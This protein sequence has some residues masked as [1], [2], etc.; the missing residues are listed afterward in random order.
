MKN[1]YFKKWISLLVVAGMLATIGTGLIYVYRQLTLEK[2]ILE[3][4]DK[5]DTDDIL[6]MLQRDWYW[7]IAGADYSPQLLPKYRAMFK[8]RTPNHDLNKIGQLKIKVIRKDG[9]L[10]G[11]IAYHMKTSTNGF[12]LF[13]DINPSYRG[14]GYAEKLIQYALDDF[15]RL[16]AIY[17]RIF[18]RTT[19]IH[20]QNLYKRM[21]FQETSR[22]DG[23]MWFQKFI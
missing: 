6:D 22:D 9:N 10:V 13:L 2:E 19:N 15:K 17:V 16:G 12:L 23:Y 20:A 5:R 3:F 1:S 8:Y 7:L 21:G 11:F 4:E 14:K 18:T